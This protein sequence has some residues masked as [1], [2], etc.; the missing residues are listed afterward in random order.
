MTLF[1]SRG[2][3]HPNRY[4]Y[5]GD[6]SYNPKGIATQIR[7][8]LCLEYLPGSNAALIK[9][10]LLIF[11]PLAS[12]AVTPLIMVPLLCLESTCQESISQEALMLVGREVP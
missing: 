9:V 6:L 2:L 8:L 11:S 12:F 4:V 1:P 3:L 7:P 10:L 5:S